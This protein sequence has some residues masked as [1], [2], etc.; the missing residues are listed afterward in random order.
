MGFCNEINI[1]LIG[2][3]NIICYTIVSPFN[4]E[5]IFIR[6]V[7]NID[8]SWSVLI[9][10]GPTLFMVLSKEDAV[11]NWRGV[12]G[13]TDPTQAKE[14]APNRYAHVVHRHILMPS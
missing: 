9:F 14:Q 8:L 13:P 7:N 4:M 10:S 12:I 11:E 3:W 6:P 2:F 1:C 5:S